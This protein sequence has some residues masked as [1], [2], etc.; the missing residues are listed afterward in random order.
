M[1]LSITL[2][3]AIGSALSGCS[4]ETRRAA[5]EPRA[6]EVQKDPAECAGVAV[7]GQCAETTPEAAPASEPKPSANGVEKE[8]APSSAEARPAAAT[9]VGRPE[10]ACVAAD[11]AAGEP[12]GAP[13]KERCADTSAAGIVVC[14]EGEVQALSVWVDGKLTASTAAAGI[15]DEMQQRVVKAAADLKLADAAVA[16]ALT[17]GDAGILRSQ[18]ARLNRAALELGE[19]L[20]AASLERTTATVQLLD[21]LQS[22]LGCQG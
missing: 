11:A 4:R 17:C 9:P 5:E 13:P 8:P 1:R 19:A 20:G 16:K 10:T 2:L 7:G 3:I 6:G 18:V 21:K 14:L 22:I 12:C 15:I